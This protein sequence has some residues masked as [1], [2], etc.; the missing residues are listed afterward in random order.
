MGKYADYCKQHFLS[1][2]ILPLVIILTPPSLESKRPKSTTESKD[3]NNPRSSF[4]SFLCS[5]SSSKRKGPSAIDK[6]LKHSKFVKGEK[7]TNTYN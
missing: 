4:P 1:L 2:L 5:S 7:I 6:A 3:G